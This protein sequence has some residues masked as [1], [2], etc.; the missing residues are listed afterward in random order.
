LKEG[1]RNKGNRR[2]RAEGE[3]RKKEK[4]KK[5][6]RR[7]EKICKSALLGLTKKRIS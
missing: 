1:R 2:Q 6:V 4:G 3:R 7:K 5:K